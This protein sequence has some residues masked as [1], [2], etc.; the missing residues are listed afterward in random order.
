MQHINQLFNAVKFLISDKNTTLNIIL[1]V[2]FS[3]TRIEISSRYFI[4]LVFNRGFNAKFTP[5]ILQIYS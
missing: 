5:I 3:I 2:T 1:S 4:L